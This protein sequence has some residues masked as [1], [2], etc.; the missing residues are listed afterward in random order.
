MW[1]LV[2][3]T[4]LT[5]L[6]HYCSTWLSRGQLQLASVYL[7]ETRFA[8][9]VSVVT[10]P[11]AAVCNLIVSALLWK[12]IGKFK[13]RF[14][15]VNFISPFSLECWVKNN[16]H[17]VCIF[18]FLFPAPQK[19]QLLMFQKLATSHDEQPQSTFP[20]G[21]EFN[22]LFHIKSS[23]SNSLKFKRL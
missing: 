14:C 12:E 11:V 22:T 2:V 17:E 16:S 7:K 19:P 10:A 13:K 18:S 23:F 21:R 8:P 1:T 6:E 20:E 9:E 3:N 15:Y 4:S 5:H